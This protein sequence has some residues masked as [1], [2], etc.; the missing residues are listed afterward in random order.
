MSMR[1]TSPSEAEETL[2]QDRLELLAAASS[3]LPMRGAPPN[4]NRY[5]ER[6]SARDDYRQ[7]ITRPET[8]PTPCA[9]GAASH[10]QLGWKRTTRP[11][12]GGYPVQVAL[13]RLCLI[14]NRFIRRWHSGLAHNDL[15]GNHADG[16]RGAYQAPRKGSYPAVRDF[17]FLPTRVIRGSD[18][19]QRLG[20]VW[21][22]DASVCRCSP[23][24]SQILG[25]FWLDPTLVGIERD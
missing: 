18:L 19:G 22:P 13:P 12:D 17:S 20:Q 23:L 5:P 14:T 3:Q 1:P 6:S 15:S 24:V 8:R 4:D 21:A 9:R 2:R 11:D 7:E 16:H 25:G 10:K